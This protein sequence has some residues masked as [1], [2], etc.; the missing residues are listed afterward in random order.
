MIEPRVDC[1]ILAAVYEEGVAEYDQIWSP[2]ILPPAVSVVAALDLHSATRIIDVG[3]GSGALTA[4][5]A[6]AA[7]VAIVVST[8]VSRAM[9]RYAEEHRK[10]TA[11][12]A[13]ASM[14]PAA[15]GIVDAVLL[16][17]VLFHLLDPAGGL[18]EARRVL[19]V[20]G[21]AGTV[22]WAAESPPRAAVVWD[23]TLQQLGVPVL[24]AHGNHTGLDTEDAIEA[25]HVMAGLRPLRVWREYIEHTFTPAGFWQM[26]TRCGCNRARIAAIDEH[27][28]P[29]VLHQ[30]RRRLAPLDPLHDYTF[31]GAVVCAVSERP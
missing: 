14:L 2:V 7:P 16:A 23:E 1:E 17:Y 20:G 8:D 3:A 24:A 5:L 19:R 25:L 11:V 31:R 26:R 22:T 30:L 10:V 18:N 15:A 21:R 27:V 29:G 6:E 28:R 9:L 4:A 13:D 12:Q